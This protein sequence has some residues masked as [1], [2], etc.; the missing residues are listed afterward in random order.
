MLDFK[1]YMRWVYAYFAISGGGEGGSGGSVFGLPSFAVVDLWGRREGSVMANRGGGSFSSQGGGGDGLYTELWKASAGPLVEVPRVN[2]KVF[3][4]PQGHM[5][6]L[7]ASTNHELN[8]KH[9]LFK[10]SSKILCR[11]VDVRL[12]AEQETDEVY[13]QITLMPDSNQ[14]EPTNPD[15]S[16]PEFSGTI[17]GVD[18]IS[19]HWPNSKW[20]SLRIQWDEL[21]SIPRPDRVSPWEIEPF[22]APTSPSI[23]Q[24]VSVKNKR[25][26]PPLDI[27]DSDNST[28][29]TLRHPGST[30]SHDDR[31]QHS[32][33]AAEM[34]RFE[35]HATWNYKQTDVSS[36]GNSVSRTPKEGSWLASPNGSVSQHRLQN[37]TD[38]RN[39][40]YVWSTVFSGAPAA[41]STCP[42]PHP[43]NPKSSD[44]VNDLGEKGRKTEVAPSCRLFGIDIIGHSKSPV[45]PEM[46]AD[47]PI[48]A[49]NEITDAEQNSDQ[50][51]ASKE[52]KLGLL[53]VPPKEIQHKQSSS[54]NSRSRTKVQM[55]GMAVGR[56]VDLT[57]LEGYGQ[58]IDELE[59][60]F[61]IKGELHPR[62][63]WEIVFTDDEGD[64]MLMG[65]YPWQE[66]CNMV[67]RIY[68]WSSQDVKMM[69]SVSNLTMSAMECDGTVITSE[70]ADS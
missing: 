32:V 17:V 13:A 9:P 6:Q 43:S 40:N 28:V 16:P 57:M 4:F 65:D 47:Q 54:T 30:Q 2:D 60:M 18:D 1:T 10:L 29:T 42:A 56:A 27:P 58:L 21:A 69:S 19:P 37:L 20:R 7:E 5:E 3:Y 48:S 67:R 61:D 12:L 68:I 34:K 44:Q 59:K 62:D 41:Q 51:K 31:T 70:S 46:A 39:S 15:P 24:S 49:P 26:R 33:A 53:Q 45:P 38:D 36:I 52:R 22:V 50:P 23:P 66:F 63:K 35:N 55:Q 14:E 25:L 64:T 11:V 8:Q